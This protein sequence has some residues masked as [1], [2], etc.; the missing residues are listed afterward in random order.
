MASSEQDNGS[1]ELSREEANEWLFSKCLWILA[2]VFHDQ[3]DKRIIEQA[4]L[5]YSEI[6][7]FTGVKPLVEVNKQ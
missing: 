4:K 5:T 6:S 2:A 3:I 1:R 7:Q